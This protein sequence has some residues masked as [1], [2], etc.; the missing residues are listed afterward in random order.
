MKSF[1]KDNPIY[2]GI[3]LSVAFAVLVF[4]DM[5]K[6]EQDFRENV[7]SKNEVKDTAISEEIAKAT[8]ELEKTENTT[9]DADKLCNLDLYLVDKDIPKADDGMVA[10]IGF[11]LE[12]KAYPSDWELDFPIPE[13]MR[14]VD[15]ELIPE[16]N[17]YYMML[18]YTGSEYD[19]AC[20]TIYS[21]AERGWLIREAHGLDNGSYVLFATNDEMLYLATSV[22]EYDPD[23]EGETLVMVT[24]IPGK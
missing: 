12:E 10:D 20:T 2:F 14:L 1:F 8:K 18:R 23:N 17:V 15:Y 4:Y 3:F 6:P 7:K 21:Q 22:I 24:F 9:S 13:N 16:E 11:P 5:R 19:A